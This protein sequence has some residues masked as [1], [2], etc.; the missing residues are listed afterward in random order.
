MRKEIQ[1]EIT[2]KCSLNCAHCSSLSLRNNY[3]QEKVSPEKV[4][5]LIK[6]LPGEKHIYFTGGE[7]LIA[8]NL[9]QYC[10]K[11][12]EKSNATLGLFSS[13]VI[14]ING[15]LRCVSTV[16]AEEL[17]HAGI[18]NCY[19]SLYGVNADIHNRI[20]GYDSFQYTCQSIENMKNAGIHIHAHVVL[21]RLN[22]EHIND[23]YTFAEEYGIE[24]VRI[25]H[26]VRAGMAIQTWNTI[27]IP[28]NRQIETIKQFLALTGNYPKLSV[29]VSGFPEIMPC[30]PDAY[31]LGC[32]RGSNVI[33]ITF[34][35]EVYPC[36]CAKNIKELKLGTLDNITEV[37]RLIKKYEKV[38]FQHKCLIES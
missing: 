23:F 21:N 36:A 18:T 13:G 8:D 6:L 28:L 32:Q 22:I 29:S 7:P 24:S 26:L 14:N 30:R 33:F 4:A 3:L 11:I 2:S 37:L 25:L 20:T 1:I 19:I 15:N 17:K 38:P 10:L 35:G 16:E 9:E 27:G 31:A 34:E 12:R 5:S